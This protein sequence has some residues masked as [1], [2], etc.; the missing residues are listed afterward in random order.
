MTLSELLAHKAGK[1][2]GK[3]CIKFETR[4]LSYAEVDRRVTLS[5]G[6]LKAEGLKRKDRVAVLMENSPEY[7]ILYFS[8]LRAG[9]VVIPVNTFLAPNEIAYILN[10]SGCKT[11]VHSSKFATHIDGI[12]K[13]TEGVRII[14]FDRIPQRETEVSVS[15]ESDIAVFLYTSGTTGFPEGQCLLTGTF[16]QTPK[17]V[18]RL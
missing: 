2:P 15:D 7:I 9:G 4:K 12:E 17:H 5:A 16:Y 10:D 11:L 3:T 14:S 13:N 1:T 8:I 6:G 18:Q